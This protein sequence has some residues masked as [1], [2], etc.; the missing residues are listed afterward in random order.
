VELAE[1]S[2]DP[3]GRVFARGGAHPTGGRRSGAAARDDL[4]R[5]A[6]SEG[7]AAHRRPARPSSIPAR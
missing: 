2:A 1:L 5:P 4:A 6:R 7:I 3:Y